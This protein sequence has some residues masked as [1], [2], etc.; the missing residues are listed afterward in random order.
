M[1]RMA[2][3]RTRTA[4]L[5]SALAVAWG[6]V[7]HQ[8]AALPR[9]I[10]G[11]RSTLADAR[12]TPATGNEKTVAAAL[13]AGDNRRIVAYAGGFDPPFRVEGTATPSAG[14]TIGTI[15][16]YQRVKLTLKGVMTKG[17]PLAILEDESGQTYIGA[18]GEEVSGQRIVTI[19]G[20]RVVLRDRMGTN[21]LSVKE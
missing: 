21:E 20:T 16:S 15:G 12:Q 5:I 1:S 2:Q 7:V 9:D 6:V 3:N 18:V 8:L 13:H 11:M 4:L 17:R 14:S 10:A 19:D